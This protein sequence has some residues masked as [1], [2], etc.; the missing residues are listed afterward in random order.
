VHRVR[1]EKNRDVL[2]INAYKTALS[3][4]LFIQLLKHH[5]VEDLFEMPNNFDAPVN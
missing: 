5:A 2:Q 4:F 3:F 1:S